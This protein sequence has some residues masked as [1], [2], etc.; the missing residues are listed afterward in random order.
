MAE[1]S[2][3]WNGQILRK[4]PEL[5]PNVPSGVLCAVEKV[6]RLGPGKVMASPPS[7]AFKTLKVWIRLCVCVYE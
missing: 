6:R 5:S 1:T 4:G 3:V 2:Y 7:L